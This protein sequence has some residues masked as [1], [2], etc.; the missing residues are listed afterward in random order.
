VTL[1]GGCH[2]GAKFIRMLGAGKDSAVQPSELK[3][4][5]LLSLSEKTKLPEPHCPV[6]TFYSTED[7]LGSGY[8]KSNKLIAEEIITEPKKNL[9]IDGTPHGNDLLT[10]DKTKSE[11]RTEIDL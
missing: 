1:I 7:R 6:L 3:T 4:I 11:V 5:I 2:G 8:Q 9:L 10:D